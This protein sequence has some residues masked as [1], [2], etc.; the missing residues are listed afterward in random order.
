MFTLESY[1]PKGGMSLKSAREAV[2][3]ARERARAG[4]EPFPSEEENL[5][6]AV[7]KRFGRAYVASLGPRSGEVYAS[8]RRRIGARWDRRLISGITDREIDALLLEIRD[9]AKHGKSGGVGAH[10]NAYST[11][12]VFFRYCWQRNLVEQMPM[13]R[14]SL[15][16]KQIVRRR[17]LSPDE[18]VQI[19]N[20]AGE[21]SY[22]AR[23]LIRF[24]LLVPVRIWSEAGTIARKDVT[25]GVWRYTVQKTAV[26]QAMKLPAM[27]LGILDEC[28]DAGRLYFRKAITPGNQ[29][30]IKNRINNNADIELEDWVFHD[31]R[32][33]FMTHLRELG[34]PF[35]IADQ[36]Q[37][38]I[39]NSS[40]GARHY[41][42]SERI[43]EKGEV[44]DYWCYVF[45]CY[46]KNSI[47]MRWRDWLRG[48][49]VVALERSA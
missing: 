12:K 45:R 49:D 30:T 43:D 11:L 2:D 4:L 13:G 40:A 5:F 20:A 7:W 19:W 33:A 10:N 22:P 16:N 48:A 44:L 26:D 37:R 21:E 15:P 34:V 8:L 3:T 39:D 6:P 18:L 36:I 9:Q 31:I 17:K 25:D 32:T 29:V 47:P 1:H 42:L 28:L 24:A 35:E 46:L 23:Q 27:A 41:D 14:M 38:P